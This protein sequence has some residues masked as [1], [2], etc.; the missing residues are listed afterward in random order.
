MLLEQSEFGGNARNLIYKTMT[1]KPI[2]KDFPPQLTDEELEEWTEKHMRDAI[3]GIENDN[4]KN[5]VFAMKAQLGMSEIHKR[6]NDKMNRNS[7]IV[8]ITAVTLSVGSI[9][10]QFLVSKSPTNIESKE[11]NEIKADLEKYQSIHQSDSVLF[12]LKKISASNIK[13]HSLA[14]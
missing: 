7:F 9:A 3:E 11:L 1:V 14:N 4:I 10:L 5:V 2:N 6:Q 13:K 8:A 12:Y